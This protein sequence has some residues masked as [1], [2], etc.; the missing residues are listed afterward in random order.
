[1]EIGLIRMH[2]MEFAGPGTE[3]QPTGRVVAF[4]NAVVFQP[5][6]GLFRQIPG[7]SLIWHEI[8]LTLAADSDYRVVEE[9]IVPAVQAAFRKYEPEFE[10]MRR[11]MEMNLSSVAIGSLTPKVHLRLTAAGMEVL[12]QFPVE[13]GNAQEID[14]RITEE[15][16]R[17]IE[18]EPKLRVV[19]AEVPT[20]RLKSQAAKAG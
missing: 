15:L 8:T 4:S 11:R 14:E 5:N 20:V 6:A 18:T 2:V 9:R 16:L 13:T 7:A 3:T 1:V 12:V 19:G 17:A 10:K